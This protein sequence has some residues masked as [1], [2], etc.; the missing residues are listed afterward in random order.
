MS[1]DCNILKSNGSDWY[2]MD[3]KYIKKAI[4]FKIQYLASLL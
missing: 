2:H 4:S 1:F 3:I